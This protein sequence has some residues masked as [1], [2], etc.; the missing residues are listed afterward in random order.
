MISGTPL[1]KLE[2]RGGFRLPDPQRLL[3]E[4]RTIVAQAEPADAIFRTN[5]ASNWLP[6]SGRL[7]RDRDRFV[8]MLDGA[9]EGRYHEVERDRERERDDDDPPSDSPWGRR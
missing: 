1:V 3:G 2:Q 6:L 4:L 7:P 5:H 8:E 9:I